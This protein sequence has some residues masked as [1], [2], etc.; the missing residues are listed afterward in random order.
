MAQQT[1]ML[2]SM[3]NADMRIV[4]HTDGDSETAGSRV[5]STT[6]SSVDQSERLPSTRKRSNIHVVTRW[7]GLG[8][9]QTTYSWYS[10]EG[11]TQPPPEDADI[12]R[13]F[14]P[15]T[16]LRLPGISV[17]QTRLYSVY[18]KWTYAFTP[19]YVVPSTSPVFA[20]CGA[21]DIDEVQRLI[22]CGKATIYDTNENGWTLLHVRSPRILLC[23]LRWLICVEVCRSFTVK[24]MSKVD[25]TWCE[26]RWDRIYNWGMSRRRAIRS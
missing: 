22:D 4:I 18:G 7:Y 10:P 5:D 13:Q 23:R 6:I 9:V 20:A 15:A 2:A 19:I 11:E 26:D 24:T 17:F 25:L 14:F 3:V 21:G 12:T 8:R 1:S 16:W